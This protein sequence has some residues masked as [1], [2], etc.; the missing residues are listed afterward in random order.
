M[1]IFIFGLPKNSEKVKIKLRII[2]FSGNFSRNLYS[3]IS[4]SEEIF[5]Y[6]NRKN[7]EKLLQLEKLLKIL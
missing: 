2:Y 7:S 4:P 6:K 5:F 1:K 3:K